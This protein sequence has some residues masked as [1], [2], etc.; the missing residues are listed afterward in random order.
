MTKKKTEVVSGE[1]VVS[2]EPVIAAREETVAEPREEWQPTT[3]AEFEWAARMMQLYIQALE[4]EQQKAKMY[5]LDGLLVDKVEAY[6]EVHINARGRDIARCREAY[7]TLAGYT[8]LIL[9]KE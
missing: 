1:P 5:S 9:P 4:A 6:V 7:E 8:A 2:E 3:D